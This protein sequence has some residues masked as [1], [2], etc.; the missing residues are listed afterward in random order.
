MTD[1]AGNQKVLQL[2]VLVNPVNDPPYFTN[3][4][5]SLT[6]DEGTSSEIINFDASDIDSNTSNLSFGIIG[7][8]S[9]RFIINPN[10]GSLTLASMPDYENPGDADGNNTYDLNV[11][12]TDSENGITNLPLVILVRDVKE[13]PTLIGS[14]LAIDVDEQI[15]FTVNLNS[16][17][18]SQGRF[19]I[20]YQNY[21]GAEWNCYHSRWNWSADIYFRDDL[22]S[23]FFR[24]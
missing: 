4:V 3:Y 8:D 13:P 11:T 14:T 17:F 5:S 16:Y 21:L 15:P 10:T 19:F 9:S 20:I 1:S 12:V 23:R 7:G 2:A 18:G 6:V 24:Y 22:Q